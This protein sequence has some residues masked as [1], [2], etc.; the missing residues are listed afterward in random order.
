MSVDTL[1]AAFV[2]ADL[3]VFSAGTNGG[4]IEVTKSID[5]D[6]VTKMIGTV[7]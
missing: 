6:G 1:A 3:I 4:K 2:N 5:G 7:E